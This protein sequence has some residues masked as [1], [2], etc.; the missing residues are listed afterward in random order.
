MLFVLPFGAGSAQ[1]QQIEKRIALVIGNGAYQAGP[2]ATAANGAGLI[3]QT[4][5]AAGFDVVGARDLDAAALRSAFRE[6]LDKAWMAGPDTVA[7]VYFAGHAVQFDGENYLVP[8]DAR[9]DQAGDV[10]LAAIRLTD[11]TKPLAALSL[12][13]RVV[14]LDAAR[15]NSFAA[16]GERLAAGLALMRSDA[17]TVI[18]FN[19]TPGTVGAEGGA[20]YGHYATA[21][22]EMIKAGGAPLDELFARVRVRVSELTD[23]A[24]LTWD[25]SL[26]G[27]PVMLFER[28]TAAEAADRFRALLAGPLGS[29]DVHGAYLAALARDAWPVYR[30]FLA[31]H[32]DAPLAR[33]VRAVMAVQREAITW[34][35]A[36]RTDTP[37]GYWSYLSRHPHG[38]HLDA[39]RRRLTLLSAP[40]EPPSTFAAIGVELAP[41][42]GISS[43]RRP[44][45]SFADPGLGLPRPPVPVVFLSPRPAYFAEMPPPL[46]P[47]DVFVLP[48]PAS[49]H[50][51]PAGVER[52][53][54]VAPAPAN[55]I[56]AN[57]HN[58][59]G[60]NPV[61][62]TVT[63]TNPAGQSVQPFPGQA[64]AV[65]ATALAIA[66]PSALASPSRQQ[67][68][69]A[70]LPA[71][72]DPRSPSP[73][74]TAAGRSAP[75]LAPT[76]LPRQDPLQRQRLIEL[77]AARQAAEEAADERARAAEQSAQEWAE[78]AERDARERAEEAERFSE[79]A[80]QE[81]RHAARQSVLAAQRQAREARQRA[82]EATEQRGR[83]AQHRARE[84]AEQ[85]A[86]HARERE[87]ESA[88]QRARDVQHRARD[89]AEQRTR[90]AQQRARDTAEQ[91]TRE[92]QQRARDAAEQRSRDAQQRARDAAEQRSRDA[93]QRARDAAEQRS[94]DA[95]QRA[96]D[97]AEQ[98]SRDAQQRAREAAE[99]RTR[100]AQQRAREAAD[101]RAQEAEQRAREA[102]EQR[103]REAQQ[104]AR[105]AA[106]RQRR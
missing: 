85:R 4:L 77:E 70:I 62:R 21:L 6:F 40:L 66:L 49:Y 33:R 74:P 38:S 41:E 92:A 35:Q 11:L 104:R 56:G 103:A 65:A 53:A 50:P 105:E 43:P 81:E 3:A 32:P 100:D 93:Q 26:V 2:L 19:A 96:R 44:I 31:A 8:V 22:A 48:I 34:W 88:E 91:R 28:S 83:E 60:I 18:A 23:G 80:T 97:A 45:V 94:R 68:A 15:A 37:E 95:Q 9:I 101:Q 57:I 90:D 13:A 102:A 1:S 27:Q 69:A 78:A 79:Q 29:F 46:P 47:V 63:V 36:T 87:R 64:G 59:V 16:S 54:F 86:R 99:Q 106:E 75:V 52:P 14:V 98:R 71:G 25:V 89:A 61:E 55:V 67:P 12:K 58:R 39:A 42:D 84:A 82:R 76:V 10:P 7:F 51:V 73:A 20:P 5:Q 72:R 24:Q 30:D 17:A